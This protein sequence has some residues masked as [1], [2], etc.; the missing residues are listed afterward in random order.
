MLHQ[1][2]RV[3]SRS[4]LRRL[5]AARRTNAAPVEQVTTYSY[6][7]NGNLIECF[8]CPASEFDGQGSS[9]GN[10]IT[11]D[12]FGNVAGEGNVEL[13][14]QYSYEAF[15]HDLATELY[16]DRARCYDPVQGRWFSED[17]L[18]FDAGDSNLYRY[19]E[20]SDGTRSG[21]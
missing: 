1:R 3:K 13:Y 8:T 19:P 17:P 21:Q 2:S 6:D 12:A 18:G 14:G 5:E 16:D 11:Y 20:N 4:R 10:S 7:A 15:K 9:D